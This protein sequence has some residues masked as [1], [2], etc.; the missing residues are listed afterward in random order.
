MEDEMI[1]HKLKMREE[2]VIMDADKKIAAAEQKAAKNASN[3][4]AE[5]KDTYRD[6]LENQL[7]KRGDELKGMYKEVL[8]RLPDISMEITKDIKEKT[9]R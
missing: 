6:K 4:I 8:T 3:S 2:Q 7:E 5:V 9:S 1:A